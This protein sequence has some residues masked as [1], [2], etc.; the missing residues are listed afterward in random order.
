MFLTLHPKRDGALILVIATIFLAKLLTPSVLLAASPE[1]AAKHWVYLCGSNANHWQL[2]D[3]DLPNDDVISSEKCDFCSIHKAF[4]LASAV[5]EQRF[6]PVWRISTLASV[7]ATATQPTHQAV[8]L[9][10]LRAP[11][12]ALFS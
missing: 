3:A 6:T 7:V 11:P 8:H 4:K 12:I 1:Q 2:V 9:P 5:E 10:S